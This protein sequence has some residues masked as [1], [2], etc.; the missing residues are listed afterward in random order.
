MNIACIQHDAVWEDK[1]ASHRIVESLLDSTP[2]ARGSLVILPE[3]FATGFSMN[4]AAIAEA[5]DGP[6]HR[7]LA[8][9]A[10]RRGIHVLGG[11]AVQSPDGRG[12]NQ[13]VLFAPDGSELLRYQKLQPFS[14]GGEA[15][16]YEAGGQI[17]T[18]ELGGFTLCPFICYDLRFPEI[19]RR[20]VHHH[21]A[22]LFVVI[23]A[24]PLP[25]DAHW[26]TLLAAR[27][28]ENQAYVVGVNRCGHDPK[29]TY[30]GKSRI[31]DPRGQVLV[32]AGSEPAV[33]QQTL[34]PAVLQTWRRDFPALAD[35][36]RDFM[37]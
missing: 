16:H 14:L 9:L 7:F 34:D 24:W 1:A 2:V 23:A 11:I 25:R 10:V 3:M 18:V 31:I 21:H 37:A 6:S 17:V 12:R 36:R 33:I 35:M 27:A 13:A 19:F 29:H 4:V 20:A 28:I 15:E 5:V 26:V 30:F 8:E 22:S 32:E